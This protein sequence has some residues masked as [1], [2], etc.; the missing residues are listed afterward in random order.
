MHMQAIPS[1]LH[2]LKQKGV[3]DT[4]SKQ[5]LWSQN[6]DRCDQII[7][8]TCMKFSD[9]KEEKTERNGPPSTLPYACSA[10]AVHQAEKPANGTWKLL[11]QIVS[12]A[13]FQRHNPEW[14][15]VLIQVPQDRNR[16]FENLYHS[17]SKHKGRQRK[18][19]SPLS[20][21]HM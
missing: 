13:L 10:P 9:N 5:Y 12:A 6:R 14:P 21:S 17:Q 11:Q 19:Y 1:G 4:G 8:C 15:E 20:G 7:L 3:C 16:H 18:A 2:G